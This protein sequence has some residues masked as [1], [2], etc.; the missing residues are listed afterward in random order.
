MSVSPRPFSRS[1]SQ[2]LAILLFSSLPSHLVSP[3]AGRATG[4]LSSLHDSMTPKPV[5]RRRRA[6]SQRFFCVAMSHNSTE[7]SMIEET[8]VV[9][10]AFWDRLLIGDF[11]PSLFWSISM[12]G[13]RLRAL[14]HKGEPKVSDIRPGSPRLGEILTRHLRSSC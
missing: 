12:G 3:S 11:R 7:L 1:E 14:S 9:S 2:V 5:A 10:V 4:I 6:H 13:R 8:V